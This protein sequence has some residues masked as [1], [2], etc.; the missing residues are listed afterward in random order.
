MEKL[1]IILL[2]TNLYYSCGKENKSGPK[3]P[4]ENLEAKTEPSP[5][6]KKVPEPEPKLESEP[7][8]TELK[9]PVVK[10]IMLQTKLSKLITTQINQKVIPLRSVLLDAPFLKR[11]IKENI[12]KQKKTLGTIPNLF[13]IDITSTKTGF[14]LIINNNKD[15]TLSINVYSSTGVVYKDFSLK[16]GKNVIA[17]APN[18]F[19]DHKIYLQPSIPDLLDYYWLTIFQEGK[20]K[21]LK[22]PATYSL[23]EAVTK[24]DLQYIA[25]DFEYSQKVLTNKELKELSNDFQLWSSFNSTTQNLEYIPVEN[26]NIYLIHYSKN[27][28]LTSKRH[29]VSQAMLSSKN[30]I[31]TKRV[32][33]V[34]KLKLTITGDQINYGHTFKEAFGSLR[35]R[36]RAQ[37]NI[38]AVTVQKL[39][40]ITT[41][42]DINANLQFY[43]NGV[44]YQYSELSNFSTNSTKDIVIKI[45][46][47]NSQEKTFYN[48]VTTTNKNCDPKD[49]ITRLPQKKNETFSLSTLVKANINLQTIQ[50]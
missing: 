8:T 31:F 5:A 32:S 44:E 30:I 11:K 2:I 9:I 35:R 7:K 19:P 24:A 18:L 4:I 16:V 37:F 33:R 43:L 47:R 14:S 17:L 38:C 41:P 10:K 39:K 34:S 3:V 15:H 26:S 46:L 42:I 23:K 25:D 22:I 12:T 1:L 40:T 27:I 36:S 49:E 29:P 45:A 50:L 6:T 20:T 13:Y 48:R 21:T 28:L